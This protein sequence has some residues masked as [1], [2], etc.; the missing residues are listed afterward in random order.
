M[1]QLTFKA[2]SIAKTFNRRKVF[3]EIS[4]SLANNQSI[5]VAGRNGSGKSTLLKI[6]AGVLSPSK[7]EIEMNIGNKTIKPADY[8]V[9]LGL[10]SPYL[11]LYDEFTGWENLDIF[12][13]VRGINTPDEYLNE[14]LKR[15]NLWERRNDFVRTYSSGMKQRLKYAFALIHKPPIL[16]LDEPTSNLD[17]EGI[18]TVYQIMEEQK[19][20]GILIVATNDAEDI[21]QCDQVIDL[22]LQIRKEN[23]K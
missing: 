23:N 21:K 10:V 14:L 4:F 6:L 18:S 7:G 13:K 9:H 16:L 20:N 12:R 15:V 19:K 22:N 3:T 5:A 17:T 1:N 8:F 11:Q 2:V